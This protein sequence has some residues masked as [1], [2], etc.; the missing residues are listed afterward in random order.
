MRVLFDTNVLISAGLNPRGVP[1]QAIFKSID[2][3][4]FVVSRINIEE[5]KEKIG[6]K[7]KSKQ[8]QMILFLQMLEQLADVVEVSDRVK[9]I[10]RKIRDI[11]DRPILRAALEGNVDVIVT[12]DKDFLEAK[13]DWP[14]IMTPAEF[15]DYNEPDDHDPCVAEP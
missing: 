2:V 15:L 11:K 14:M 1:A 10:E 12:G 9:T 6:S 8:K 3:D 13:I 7:F 5:F 4:T